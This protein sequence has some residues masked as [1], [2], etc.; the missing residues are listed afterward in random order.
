MA[1][2]S[3]A[4]SALK[5]FK[6]IRLF[7]VLRPG[8]SIGIVRVPLWRGLDMYFFECVSRNARELR[9]ICANCRVSRR[10]VEEK[11]QYES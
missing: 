1:C 11:K 10:V 5:K 7:R 8:L 6:S 2:S 4:R 3:L 9:K